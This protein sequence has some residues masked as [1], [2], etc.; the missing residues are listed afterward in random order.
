VIVE[1]K[2][3]AHVLTIHEAQILTY[4]K[5]MKCPAGLLLNF[6]VPLMKDGVRRILNRSALDTISVPPL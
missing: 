1:V 2:S 4:M 5:L 6:N 3:V